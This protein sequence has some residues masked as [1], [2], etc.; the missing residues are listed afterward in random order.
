M[1]ES[2]VIV[3]FQNSDVYRRETGADLLKKAINRLKAKNPKILEIG[4]GLGEI[5]ETA[6]LNNNLH[7]QMVTFLEPNMNSST[8]LQAKFPKSTV[9]SSNLENFLKMDA[10]ESKYDLIFAN[11]SLHWVENLDKQIS[12][13]SNLL[14][15]GGL[16]V[17]ANTDSSRSFWGHI[18]SEVQNAFHGSKLF[19]IE[20]SHSMDD[21]QWVSVFT[22]LNEG[23][24]FRAVSLTR[25]YGV[26]AVF[27]SKE[28][29]LENFKS[30]VGS[31]YLKV[32]TGSSSD[33]I[34]K[35]ILNRL[36]KLSNSS[37]EIEVPASGFQVIVEK[38]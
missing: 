38:I 8:H 24:T 1:K 6:I 32:G 3:N 2:D 12:K 34:E 22:S 23:G 21:A 31:K 33:G 5:M 25:L 28:E 11:F 14:N 15:S 13:L 19:N 30:I 29:C 10:K 4:P 26:A 36:E 17:F 37:G 27:K 18:D 35:F 9:V 7:E 16:I 20:K